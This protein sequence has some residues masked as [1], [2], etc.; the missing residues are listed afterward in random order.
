MVVIGVAA[1][2]GTMASVSRLTWAFACD[3]PFSDFLAHVNGHHQIPTRA[4]SLVSIVIVLLSLINIGS[5]VA[6]K[7]LL[8][9]S[10][11]GSYVS[12]IIPIACLL[13]K[14]LRVSTNLT[15]PGEA[16]ISDHAI[17]F[18]PWTLGRFGPAISFYALCYACLMVPFTAL[19]SFTPVDATTMNYAGLVF[20]LVLLLAL[21]GYL[22]RR[23]KRFTGP[24]RELS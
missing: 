1:E 14:R 24:A 16:Y 17:V 22:V 5:T 4:I 19:P 18:G 21:V 11:I 10:T 20:G 8:S 9:L 23:R 3:L 2:F 15:A 12:Y 7:A 6:F 13:S